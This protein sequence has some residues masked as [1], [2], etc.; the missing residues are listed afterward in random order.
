MLFL[1][2]LTA[3]Q[4]Q[5]ENAGWLFL[6]HKQEISEKIDLRADV[7]LRSADRFAFLS[8][9]LLRGAVSCNINKSNSVALG[10]A[11]LGKWDQDE[12]TGITSA[13]HRIFEQYMYEGKLAKVEVSTRLRLEQRFLDQ[14]GPNFSQRGR[15]FISAQIPVL[16]NDDFSKGVYLG[17]QN[18]LFLNIQY[19]QNANG[20]T[21]DQNR[22]FASVGYRWSK[23]IDTEFGYMYWRQKESDGMVK[24]NVLQVM[25][26][27]SF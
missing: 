23:K 20:N 9:L 15:V 18:E 26:T 4:A 12:G 13:E 14:P 3:A 19:K 11:F 1:C 8:A 25:V 2:S 21:F 6:T 17:L 16:A 27:T 7:Q 22:S 10:Y 5:H 24:Q